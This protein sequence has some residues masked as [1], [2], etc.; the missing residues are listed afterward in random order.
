MFVFIERNPKFKYEQQGRLETEQEAIIIDNKIKTL[1]ESFPFD[2]KSFI[3]DKKNVTY[4]W[5]LMI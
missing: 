1:V 5:F 4:L 2:Y 3:S